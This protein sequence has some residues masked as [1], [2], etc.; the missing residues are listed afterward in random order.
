L[1]DT[2]EN[3]RAASD[4]QHRT[5]VVAP[6]SGKI[7]NLRY[8]TVGGVVKPG[9]AILDIVPQNDKLVIY[10]EV[11]PLDI[12]AVRPG[13]PAEVRLIAY[14]QRRVPSVNGTVTYVSADRVASER[15]GQSYYEARVEID[16]S[17]LAQLDNVNLY[18]GMPADVLITIGERTLLQY[19]LDPIRDSFARAFRER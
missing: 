2:E 15:G 14:K 6:Q 16:P 10:A 19:L 8:F 13:L 11:Q 12:E 5:D 17:E 4:V 1:A 18:P 9:D 7:V 3:L